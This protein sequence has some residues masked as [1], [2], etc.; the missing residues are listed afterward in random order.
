MCADKCDTARKVDA[1]KGS[2]FSKG[3]TV[4]CTEAKWQGDPLQGSAVAKCI[5]S[6]GFDSSGQENYWTSGAGEYAD[7]PTCLQPSYDHRVRSLS[8][9][10]S[11][12]CRKGSTSECKTGKRWS[13]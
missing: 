3:S 2:T 12:N 4:N 13:T 5:L 9:S 6:Y 7:V 8:H 10:A 11:S 1:G